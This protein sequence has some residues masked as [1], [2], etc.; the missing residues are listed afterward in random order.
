MHTVYLL[1]DPRTNEPRYVGV[2]SR[3]VPIR[4]QQ[5]RYQAKAG[6]KRPVC[7]WIRKLIGLGL[8]P[9]VTILE[10]AEDRIR[11][12]HWIAVYRASGHRMLNITDGG[13]AAPSSNPLVAAK[14]SR[15]LKGRKLSP[16]R[17]ANSGRPVG[18]KH[19]E[20]TKAKMRKPKTPE[21][22]DNARAAQMAKRANGEHRLL[23]GDD[24]PARKYPERLAR[25]ANQGSAKLTDAQVIEM[26]QL[27]AEG[28]S[29]VRLAERFSIRQAN[30][31][32]IVRGL[33]WAHLPGAT[34]GPG[35]GSKAHLRNNKP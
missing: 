14:I 11:E 12:A 30:A 26:R 25:G 2:T 18:Y 21:H 13:N 1:S 19:T 5:H 24:N 32:R 20:A 4:M 29:T 23:Y 34:L 33:S 16:E 8:E 15:A 3:T 9:I 35:K 17:C 28:V 27:A 10:V 7:N 6:K 22:R 31:W